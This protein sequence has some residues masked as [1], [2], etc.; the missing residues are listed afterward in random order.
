MIVSVNLHTALRQFFPNGNETLIYSPPTKKAAL[1]I[2][3][4][5]ILPY[6]CLKFQLSE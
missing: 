5:N 4:T 2:E 6:L 3:L 1:T